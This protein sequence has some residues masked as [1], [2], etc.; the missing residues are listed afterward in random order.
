M[1]ILHAQGT[2]RPAPETAIR[3]SSRLVDLSVSVMDP[4]TRKAVEGLRERDFEI[5]DQGKPRKISH[6]AFRESAPPL[7]IIFLVK[8]STAEVK[9]V[10]ELVKALPAA[11]EYLPEGYEI[12]IAQARPVVEL[13]LPPTKDRSQIRKSLEQIAA[14]QLAPIP[15]STSENEVPLQGILPALDHFSVTQSV[16]GRKLV[17]V[18]ISNDLDIWWTQTTQNTVKTLLSQ[19]TLA[20]AF[21]NDQNAGTMI[22]RTMVH[23]MY[24]TSGKRWDRVE[25]GTTYLADQTGGPVIRIKRKKYRE[26]LEVL[27]QQLSNTYH[28]SFIPPEE[29]R[30]GSFR[31]LSVQVKNLRLKKPQ[32]LYRKGYWAVP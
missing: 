2:E 26:A 9:V 11:I 21:L 15:Q 28:L 8:A 30:D 10:N 29:E 22:A 17:F 12:G 32:I 31:P 3:T 7:R 5:L 4:K 24:S 25:R 16:R 27:L 20:A 6:F 18:I 13:V 23:G 14:K 19:G 1:A